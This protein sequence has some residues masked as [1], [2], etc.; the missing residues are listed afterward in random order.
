MIQDHVLVLHTFIWQNSR[1]K[2]FFYYLRKHLFLVLIHSLAWF[3][4]L[5][6]SPLSP[7]L[8]KYP[9]LKYSGLSSSFFNPNVSCLQI[10]ILVDI[11][12]FHTRTKTKPL[13]VLP[14]ITN[15]SKKIIFTLLGSGIICRLSSLVTQTF[16]SCLD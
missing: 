14:P 4:G 1:L 16:I 15:P 3:R 8:R 6:P 11:N 12:S 7:L 9:P 10:Y 13:T 5:P 2:F